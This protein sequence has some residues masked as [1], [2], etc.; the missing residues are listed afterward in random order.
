MGVQLDR[1]GRL[2]EARHEEIMR[3]TEEVRI[4]SQQ[5]DE[6]REL[7]ARAEE[8]RAD[9][10]E[11]EDEGARRFDDLQEKHQT[12]LSRKASL[13]AELRQEKIAADLANR[14]ANKALKE[15]AW[16][17]EGPETQALLNAKMTLAEALGDVDE[18][19]LLSRRELAKIQK[20]I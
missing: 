13:E 10:D 1:E 5:V 18:A 3:L 14:A 8:E 4:L 2:H 11:R 9:L 19:R 6:E 7:L 12:A 15:G 16:A 20:E 17:R